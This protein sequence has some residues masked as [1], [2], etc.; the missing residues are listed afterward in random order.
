MSK[1]D[2][3]ASGYM[4]DEGDNDYESVDSF[5]Q[6]KSSQSLQSNNNAKSPENQ[7]EEG[8]DWN[9]K[10]QKLLE[11]SFDNLENELS[12]TL[13]LR[14][15]CLEFAEI[16]QEIGMKII[17]Q[18]HAPKEQQ[19]IPSST[20]YFGGIAGGNQKII[21]FIIKGEKYLHQGIFFKV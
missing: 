11:K 12:R 13:E 17:N 19:F 7:S 4:D 2:G 16:A 3:G 8:S 15:L 10:F 9:E 21:Y 6:E 1:K 20:R 5:H 14:K 18:L